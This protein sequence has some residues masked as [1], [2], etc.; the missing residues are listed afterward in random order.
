MCWV[1]MAFG[2]DCRGRRGAA[3]LRAGVKA[4]ARARVVVLDE[5]V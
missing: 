4:E 2:E 3:D 1:H 5:R